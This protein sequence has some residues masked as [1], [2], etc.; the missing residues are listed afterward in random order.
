MCQTTRR[1][2]LFLEPLE[3]R[4]LLA[5]KKKRHLLPRMELLER[6][7]CAGSMLFSLRG[8]FATL[9]SAGHRAAGAIEDVDAASLASRRARQSNAETPRKASGLADSDAGALTAFHAWLTQ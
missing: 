9:P 2:R 1:R 7:D 8:L 6:R 3:D 5:T 4:R